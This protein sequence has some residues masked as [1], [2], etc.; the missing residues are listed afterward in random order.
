M[1]TSLALIH[2]PELEYWTFGATAK[3][4]QLAINLGA[5]GD[6]RA[7]NGKL[8]VEHP[9]VGGNSAAAPVTIEPAN[10]AP[11]RLHSSTI[12]GDGL[13]W[14]AASGLRGVKSVKL[15]LEKKGAYRLRLH[16]LEP[17]EL[18]ARARLFDIVINDQTVQRQFD[19]AASAGAPRR[20]V[21][22]EF[23]VITSN[24]TIQIDLRPTTRNQ[25]I[26]SGIEW[27]PLP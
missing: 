13:K 25:P 11:F 4:G 3:L 12:K 15:K 1:Q 26:L 9:S 20:A 18:P 7:P 19:I 22:R 24:E 23:K 16:F 10:A 8:W 14:V 17:D 27:F 2:M 5:P 6:R 21:V